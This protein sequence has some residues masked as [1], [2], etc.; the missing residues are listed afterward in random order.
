MNIKEYFSA[1]DFI[2]N[3]KMMKA[4]ILPFLIIMLVSLL[5]AIFIAML[6]KKFYQNRSTGSHIHRAFPLLGISVTSIFITIQFS[7][8]LS[9][10]LLG[11]LS[12]VRFR[13]PVKEPEE[14]GFIMLVISASL[15]CATFNLIFL[16]IILGIAFAS[17]LIQSLL[18]RVFKG[19]DED[20]MVVVSFPKNDGNTR[21]E[22]TRVLERMI[23]EGRMDSLV[24][25]DGK[26]VVSYIFTR[27]DENK[28]FELKSS[29][30]DLSKEAEVNVYFN[31]SVR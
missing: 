17:L 2:V 4:G 11:A 16:S 20:G 21:I 29:L 6:Y 25:H 15:C 18:K 13:T 14:I 12:I 26:E 30:L 24:E 5:S 27:I 23:P 3:H 7:L 22:L 10:G 8:P 31:R 9:L 28:V 1:A 19:T